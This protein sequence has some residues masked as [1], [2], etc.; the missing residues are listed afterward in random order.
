[1]GNWL[2]T[3]PGA[4]TAHLHFEIRKQTEMCG[5]YGCPSSPYWT[6]VLAY[7]LLINMRGTEITP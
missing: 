1:V 5:S 3:E 4:T 7:E 6:L 2:K